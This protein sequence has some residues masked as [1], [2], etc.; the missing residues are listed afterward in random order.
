MRRSTSTKDP[1]GR[2]SARP[3]EDCA[4]GLALAERLERG[5]FWLQKFTFRYVSL[6]RLAINLDVVQ[7]MGTP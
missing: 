6:V 2:L 5:Q 4:I 7:A 1:H 3:V